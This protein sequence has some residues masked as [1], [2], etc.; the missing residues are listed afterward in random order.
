M[1]PCLRSLRKTPIVHRSITFIANT[2]DS[3]PLH[4]AP[5]M[6]YRRIL[7]LAA[8]LACSLHAQ[9]PEGPS[10]KTR[11]REEGGTLSAAEF[12]PQG[13]TGSSVGIT[14]DDQGK[15]YVSHTNRRNNG[16]LDIRKNKAWLL[17]SLALT[18]AEDRQALIKKKMPDT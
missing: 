13:M 4:A 3:S 18:S 15:V 16:E 17:E 12:A 5:L 10:S 14:L 9:E 1:R 6:I 8:L 2:A 11:P 7:S